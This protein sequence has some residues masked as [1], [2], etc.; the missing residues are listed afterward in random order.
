MSPLISSYPCMSA[1]FS[2]RNCHFVFALKSS[3]HP[4]IRFK[5]ALKNI[6]IFQQNLPKS[7]ISFSPG[8][9]KLNLKDPQ[10]ATISPRWMFYLFELNLHC[11]IVSLPGVENCNQNRPSILQCRRHCWLFIFR[12]LFLPPPRGLAL[13]VVQ[14][15]VICGA[16]MS[17]HLRATKRPF[18][19]CLFVFVTCN[20]PHLGW[21]GG[22]TL[23]PAA[24]VMSSGRKKS[25][26]SVLFYFV[27]KF[28]QS[29]CRLLPGRGPDQIGQIT[30]SWSHPG[31]R[32]QR[33]FALEGFCNFLWRK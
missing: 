29:C 6:S 18:A 5:K 2:C 25:T 28:S 33:A 19:R 22:K 9:D 21:L 17:P 15:A 3:I 26:R 24:G 23:P 4:G 32:S 11:R 31:S 8:T 12:T 13:G 20:F 14:F 10:S 1:K 16:N 30:F 27:R 7:I